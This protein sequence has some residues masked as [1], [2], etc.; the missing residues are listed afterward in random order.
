MRGVVQ[1]SRNGT[2]FYTSAQAPVY[3]LLVDCALYSTQRHVQ[4]GGDLEAASR[5]CGRPRWA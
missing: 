5:W 4:V 2:V 3:P 1:Y